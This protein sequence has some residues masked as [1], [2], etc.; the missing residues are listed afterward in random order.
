VESLE[1]TR[2]K[3]VLSRFADPVDLWRY[4]KANHPLVVGL[5]Q[6]LAEAPARVATL[7]RDFMEA[8]TRWS[9]GG[10]DGS[11]GYEAEYLLIV[12]RKRDSRR[13]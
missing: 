2:K 13:P 8:A 9:R 3:L 4:L 5:Y 7:D 1:I 12:A 11:A 6:E 10:P